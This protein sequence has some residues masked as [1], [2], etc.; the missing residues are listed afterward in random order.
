MSFQKANLFS[1]RY[2]L[3]INSQQVKPNGLNLLNVC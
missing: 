1:G 2:W 3:E